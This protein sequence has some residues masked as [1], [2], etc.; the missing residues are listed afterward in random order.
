MQHNTIVKGQ[1]KTNAACGVGNPAC[2][3]GNLE[4][5]ES[6]SSVIVN[7][8]NYFLILIYSLLFAFIVM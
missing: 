6:L 3:V 4:P 2:G 8:F 7:Y 5:R 1:N